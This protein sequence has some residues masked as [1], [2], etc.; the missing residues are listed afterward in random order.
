MFVFSSK[1]SRSFI[2]G[3]SEFG[4][5]KVQVS[6]QETLRGANGLKKGSQGCACDRRKML[7]HFEE[8]RVGREKFIR[9][10]RKVEGFFVEGG[11]WMV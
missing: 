6:W 4:L 10:K 2:T 1:E 5:M 7:T 8:G 9:G 11:V 3:K